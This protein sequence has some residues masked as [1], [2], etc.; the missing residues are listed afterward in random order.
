MMKTS[1]QE[2]L[3]QNS[4][5]MTVALVSFGMLFASMFLGYFLVRFNSP[6]WPPVEIENIPQL[7]PFLSTVV[8]ALSSYTYWRME[9]VVLTDESAGKKFWSLTF[10]LGLGFLALQWVLWSTLKTR[11]IL[12]ANGWVTSMVYAFTWVH[13]AHILGA[14]GTLVWLKRF[15]SKKREELTDVKVIN[16]GKFWHFLGVIWLII[17]LMM[18]VL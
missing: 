9:K 18:F 17:Y 7:L 16:V 3:L 15:I 12:V 14:L 13:A 10:I 6:V 11:G 2:K 1:S 8:M 4:I 5:A